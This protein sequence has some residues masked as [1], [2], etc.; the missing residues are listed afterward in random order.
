MNLGKNWGG[1]QTKEKFIVYKKV[2]NDKFLVKTCTEENVKSDKQVIP[3]CKP[4]RLLKCDYKWQN[5]P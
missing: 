4:R 1:K 3:N 5:Q 2:L